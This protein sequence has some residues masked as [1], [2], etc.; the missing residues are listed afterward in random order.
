MTIEDKLKVVCIVLSLFITVLYII[1]I[2]KLE[3]EK[4]R[5]KQAEE[6]LSKSIEEIEK[7][8]EG[9]KEEDIEEDKNDDE[10]DARRYGMGLYF[11]S[12]N[13]GEEDTQR[14]RSTGNFISNKSDVINALM[15]IRK[16]CGTRNIKGECENCEYYYSFDCYVDKVV[17]ELD[18]MG[19]LK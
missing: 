2:S 12:S 15:D 16:D 4:D 10:E 3:E 9:E 14:Y 17:S 6:R 5:A 8:I 1:Q 13:D 19:L 18:K 11:I 7:Y